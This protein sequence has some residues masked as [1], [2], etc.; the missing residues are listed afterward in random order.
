MT[1]P[2]PNNL[3]LNLPNAVQGVPE[4]PVVMRTGV[5]DAITEADNITVKI[6][7]SPVLV[8][9]SYLF[10]E[11]LPLLGDRVVVLRQD[12]QWF[13]VG[14]MAGPINSEILNPSFENGA[15]GAT[16]TNWTF[17]VTLNAAGN[18]TGTK[19]N[20]LNPIDGLS[21][22]LVQLLVITGVGTSEGILRSSAVP[23]SPGENWTASTFFRTGVS[24]N[25]IVAGLLNI[26][27][28]DGGGTLISSDLI[29][30]EAFNSVTPWFYMRPAPATP[31]ATAPAGTVTVR[32]ALTTQILIVNAA[33]LLTPLAEYD[34]V[35]LRRIA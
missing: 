6:S 10:P 2:T 32:V 3:D 18:P 31:Y 25:N 15:I 28:Y 24:D 16:P 33:P 35:V 5:V 20:P 19:S 4:S 23:A 11:Y 12:S 34:R 21:V 29:G 14:T 8:T 1:Q 27:W 22:A 7:G 9:A 30:G 17:T 26:E 13:V